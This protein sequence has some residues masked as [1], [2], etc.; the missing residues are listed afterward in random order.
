MNQTTRTFEVTSGTTL[1]CKGWRQEALLRLLEN[2]LAVAGVLVVVLLEHVTAKP[3]TALA[4]V[5]EEQVP[6]AP[7]ITGAKP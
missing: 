5:A 4:E 2:V 3:R 7:S 1:R 6:A